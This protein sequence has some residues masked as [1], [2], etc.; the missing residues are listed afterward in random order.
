MKEE[1]FFCNLNNFSKSL[2][3]YR[4]EFLN[5]KNESVSQVFERE[6]QNNDEIME[7]YELYKKLAKDKKDK[8]ENIT[9][10][11]GKR[12]INDFTFNFEDYEFSSGIENKSHYDSMRADMKY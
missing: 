7:I 4:K 10:S 8:L 12:I 3:Q 6:S 11:Q 1:I 2:E 9:I 5:L